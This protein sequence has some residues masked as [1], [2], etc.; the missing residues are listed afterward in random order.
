VQIP[1]V[2]RGSDA[3]GRRF[4][5][6]TE[7]VSLDERGARVRTRF[8]L[9]P[10]AVISVRLETEDGAKAMRVVW[11]GEPGSFYEGMVGMEFVEP[12]DGWKLESLRARWG[13]RKF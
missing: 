11:R 9:N 10:G 6:R 8:L 3:S 1:V 13:A 2:L 12:T 4:F 7:V 5:D